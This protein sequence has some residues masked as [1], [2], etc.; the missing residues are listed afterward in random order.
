[1]DFDVSELDAPTEG[2]K[3]LLRAEELAAASSF[4]SA[5]E[6]AIRASS[7]TT[8]A[9]RLD[10]LRVI[11]VCAIQVGDIDAAER[12]ALERH[13]LLL[14]LNKPLEAAGQARAG[15]ALFGRREQYD[16]AA[17]E[18]ELLNAED[19]PPRMQAQV[20]LAFAEVLARQENPDLERIHSLAG[21]AYLLANM[22]EDR[23]SLQFL[24][25]RYL[26]E[27]ALHHGDAESAIQFCETLLET[28]RNRTAFA[29]AHTLHAKALSGMRQ[30]VEAAHAA[31]RA[32][33]LYGAIGLPE[34]LYEA[35]LLAG[36]MAVDARDHSAAIDR[37]RAS[38]ALA[39]QCGV[40]DTVARKA[41]ASTLLVV[42]E[43]AESIELLGA[44][45][46]HETTIGAPTEQRA[47][48]L[49]WMGHSFSATEQP[50]AALNV[51]QMAISLY[52]QSPD[53]EGSARVNKDTAEIHAARGQFPLACV[54]LQNAASTLRESPS[55]PQLFVDVMQ[56]LALAQ[57]NA[58]DSQALETLDELAAVTLRDQ[59]PWFWASALAT[60]ARAQSILGNASDA[61]ATAEKAANAFRAANDPRS[62]VMTE[63]FAARLLAGQGRH[64]D[65]VKLLRAVVRNARDDGEIRQGANRELAESYEA[66]GQ[67]RRA[68]A[69][70]TLAGNTQP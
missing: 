38:A 5:L 63:R 2:E 56:D 43:H 14:E 29:Q 31:D 26:A 49:E 9:A 19:L 15:L 34:L 12:V 50:D 36:R 13:A 47:E 60:R 35:T 7:T 69:A 64:K 53:R 45:Y 33:Y 28:A 10:A 23:G 25:T 27:I 8:G 21:V 20:N 18:R 58:G 41:L 52:D 67:K 3:W 6:A 62:A 16:I 54:H 11:I 37:F 55:N 32:A 24:G 68:T 70:R 61:I 44:I 22:V 17:L 66:L 48:T 1:M 65:A 51:W 4:S 57:A 39:Q 59:A 30:P 40:D 46:N 42:G